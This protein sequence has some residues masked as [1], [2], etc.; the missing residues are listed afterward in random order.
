MKHDLTDTTFIIPLC[1]ESEDRAENASI[2]LS[3]LT[4][5]LDT[6]IIVYEVGP[7]DG[8][9]TKAVFQFNGSSPHWYYYS[10]TGVFHRTKYLNEMLAMVKT[11]IVVNYDIDVLLHPDTYLSCVQKIRSGVELMYPYFV[12]D[13]QYKVNHK[14]REKIKRTG[15]LTTLCDDDWQL[16][17]SEYGH[18]QFFSTDAYREGGGENESFISWGAE[19]QER[20]YRFQKLGFNV[21][22]GTGFIFHLE[23]SRGINSSVQN[24][25]VHRNRRTFEAIKDMSVSELRQYY[26]AKV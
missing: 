8:Y 15:N 9:R 17:R 12:G 23:H 18:C 11:P 4:K 19:D 5:H 16:D 20:A 2:T 6:N 13:S 3:Y 24:P 1:I 7:Q 21:E 25:H 22:W 10:I 14:G 26:A